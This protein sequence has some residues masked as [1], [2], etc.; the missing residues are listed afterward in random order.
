MKEQIRLE[1]KAGGR[2]TIP[3]QVRQECG[4]E[5]GDKLLVE[6][7]NNSIRLTSIEAAVKEVQEMLKPF[8]PKGVSVVDELLEERQCESEKEESEI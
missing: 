4:F 3:A 7:D 2:I 1:I 8:I 5:I 6:F